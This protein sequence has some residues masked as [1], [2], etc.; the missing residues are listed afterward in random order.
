M[1]SGSGDGYTVE[2]LEK[3]KIQGIQNRLGCALFRQEFG[4]LVEGGLSPAEDLFHAPFATKLLAEVLG[5]PFIS[6]RELVS[7]IAEPVVDRRVAESIRTL[8]LTPSR[9]T[10]F[11]SF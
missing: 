1:L 10:L 3:V 9:M 5:I 7:E 11:M 4:P 2:Q 6:Q 8:V